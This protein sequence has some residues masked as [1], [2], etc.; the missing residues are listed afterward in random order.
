VVDD[1]LKADTL[2]LDGRPARPEQVARVRAVLDKIR[3]RAAA[4][5]HAR[6]E[7]SNNFPTGAGL[8]SSASGFAAL[9]VAA[10]RAFGLS[11]GAEE[12]SR[13]ARQASGSAARSIFGGFVEMKAGVEPDG[14]D[15]HALPLLAAHAWPLEVVIAITSAGEK[16]V[17]ST[18]GMTRSQSSPYYEAW[19]RSSERDLTAARAAIAARDFA[20]LSEVSERSC[21]KMH[22]LALS[23]EPALIYWNGATVEAMH[24][25]RALRRAGAAVFFT[26]DAGP[27]LKA[28]CLPQDAARVAEALRDVP[29][30]SQVLRSPLGGNARLL[31]AE[32]ERASA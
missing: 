9:V 28:V 19:V 4:C 11:L 16:D 8:A 1:S 14:R 17:G 10:S 6:V 13:I 18:E 26:I 21:L 12:L 7:T 15:A 25:V 29:G 30:V 5:E 32:L 27:Q 23:A 22:A 20:A 24:C 31:E 3:S 2:S